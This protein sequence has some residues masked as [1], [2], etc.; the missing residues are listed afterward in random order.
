MHVGTEIRWVKTNKVPY[1]DPQANIIGII[2]FSEDITDHKQMEQE[3]Q[4]SEEKYRLLFENGTDAITVHFINAEV[5]SGH[6]IEVNEVACQLFDYSREELFAMTPLDLV[7]PIQM[8][9]VPDVGEKLYRDKQVL[10]EIAYIAKDG[11]KIPVEINSRLFDLKDQP[12]VLSIIRNITT[13]KQGEELIQQYVAQIERSNHELEQFATIT[14]H[15]LKSPLVAILGY[16]G[17]LEKN[18][19]ANLTLTLWNLL[20]A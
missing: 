5:T 13:R 11:Q 9:G 18:T 4:E 3:F 17:L 14:S 20:L 12:A 7:D 10:F 16:A 8:K 6:F 1:R 15:D 19:K 2:G